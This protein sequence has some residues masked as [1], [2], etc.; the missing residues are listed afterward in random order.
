MKTIIN[1][2]YKVIIL[3]SPKKWSNV[4]IYEDT[5]DLVYNIPGDDIPRGLPINLFVIN[6]TK[7]N[8]SEGDLFV[9]VEDPDTIHYCT[10]IDGESVSAGELQLREE[11]YDL[12]RPIFNHHP[13]KN[14]RKVIGTSIQ[15]PFF[16]V[17]NMNEDQIKEIINT[18]NNNPNHKMFQ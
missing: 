9:L 14:V 16:R 3:S 13:M 15:E 18:F 5:G 6:N 7:N 2:N 12:K 17:W 10:S 11:G 1:E 8:L 4:G